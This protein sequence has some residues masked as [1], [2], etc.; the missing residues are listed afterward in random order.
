MTGVWIE[1][2]LPT[3]ARAG[4]G[5]EQLLPWVLVLSVTYLATA[6]AAGAAR[7]RVGQ[8]W[9]SP[10][11]DLE[12][13]V[14]PHAAAMTAVVWLTLAVCVPLLRARLFAVAVALCAGAAFGPLRLVA[15]PIQ[16]NLV[17]I[18][19]DPSAAQ[20]AWPVAVAAVLT[21]VLTVVSRRLARPG[22]SSDTPRGTLVGVAGL[23][24]LAIPLIALPMIPGATV[25]PGH[26]PGLSFHMVTGWGL[27]AGGL[28]T[29]GLLGV[30]STSTA[31]WRVLL[32]AAAPATM[33]WA[34]QRDGGWPGVPGWDYGMQSPLFLTVQITAVLI[35][36][37]VL[38]W[39]LSASGL[40]E[41]LRVPYDHS[42]PSA[43]RSEPAS[44]NG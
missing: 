35:S 16:G 7:W 20:V 11:W 17:L 32:S 34:Y 13:T 14:W 44:V 15:A 27:L 39:G 28:L 4:R 31:A 6:L 30:G 12:R 8:L 26:E 3:L 21:V 40:G 33:Y 38:G 43:A 37:A 18:D 9:G 41:R 10:Q 1:N 19:R 29:A 42:A 25:D 24:C 23:M 5:R 36:C 22:P 2:N